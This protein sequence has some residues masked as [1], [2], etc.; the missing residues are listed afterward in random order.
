MA[1]APALIRSRC[2]GVGSALPV[3]VRAGVVLL[4]SGVKLCVQNPNRATPLTHS[5][6]AFDGLV[7]HAELAPRLVDDVACPVRPPW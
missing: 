3:A 5:S 2:L 4:L 1:R 7:L 6:Y